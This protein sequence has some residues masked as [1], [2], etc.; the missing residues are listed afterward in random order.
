MKIMGKHEIDTLQME[1]MIYPSLGRD[2][3]MSC[4]GIVL[5]G[6]L[7]WIRENRYISSIFVSTYS[8]KLL[9]IMRFMHF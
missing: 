7:S 9:G 3:K 6:C 8:L 5:I 4:N 2:S 1:K